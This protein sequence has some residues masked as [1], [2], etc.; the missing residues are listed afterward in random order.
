MGVRWLAVLS[1]LAI[2]VQASL[3]FPEDEEPEEILLAEPKGRANLFL[4]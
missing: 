3:S 1:G 2:L 4:R